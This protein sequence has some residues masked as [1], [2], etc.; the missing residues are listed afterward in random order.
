MSSTGW[1]TEAAFILFVL[2]GLAILGDVAGKYEL[3]I[4]GKTAAGLLAAMTGA[5]TI[6]FARIR[7]AATLPPKVGE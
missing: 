6:W 1:R 2:I 3:P 5:A 7:A 4:L